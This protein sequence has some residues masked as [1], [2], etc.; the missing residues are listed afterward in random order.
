MPNQNNFIRQS[1][2]Y[3]A[4]ST[5]KLDSTEVERKKTSVVILTLLSLIIF[6]FTLCKFEV[7]IFN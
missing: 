4:T 1:S 2:T 7:K 5:M 3:S 6:L